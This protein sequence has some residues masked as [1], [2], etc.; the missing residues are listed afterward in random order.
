MALWRTMTPREG[1]VV[2]VKRNN[3]AFIYDK[4]LHKFTFFYLLADSSR[5]SSQSSPRLFLS[6][7]L[8]VFSLQTTTQGVFST[9]SSISGKTYFFLNGIRVLSLFSIIYGHLGSRLLGNKLG[10]WWHWHHCM[11]VAHNIR[12]S[13]SQMTLGAGRRNFVATPSICCQ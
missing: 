5:Q 9:S 8:Q 6:H 11:S 7:F 13:V 1:K 12:I 3:N 2:K 10:W 4:Y